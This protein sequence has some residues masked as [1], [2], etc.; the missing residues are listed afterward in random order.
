MSIKIF[1]I[2]GSAGIYSEVEPLAVGR[3]VREM[4]AEDGG[5]P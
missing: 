1:R 2:S 4:Y 5:L 3:A